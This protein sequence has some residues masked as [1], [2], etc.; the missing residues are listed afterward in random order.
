MNHLEFHKHEMSFLQKSPFERWA[1]HVEKLLRHS[2]DGDQT[3]DGYSLDGAMEAFLA[4]HSAS[5]YACQIINKD[6]GCDGESRC[7][8][9]SATEVV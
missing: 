8:Q 3:K 1:T 5:A 6:C 9:H 4:G 2:L 7:S